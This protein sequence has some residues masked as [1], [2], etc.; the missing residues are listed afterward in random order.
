MNCWWSYWL[1]PAIRSTTD[2]VHIFQQDTAPARRA[3]QRVELLPRETLE[4]TAAGMW[5]PN[6][7]ELNLVDCRNWRGESCRNKSTTRHHRLWQFHGR[8]D[9][10]SRWSNDHW[11][12][13]LDASVRVQ[14]N[15]EQLLWH[16]LPHVYM[17][18]EFHK[19]V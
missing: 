18:F 9:E 13:R 8:L 10:C 12:K 17:S 19:V 11:W 4:F 16:C 5:L 14:G 7:L 2:E 15:F 1:L 6:S 3:R